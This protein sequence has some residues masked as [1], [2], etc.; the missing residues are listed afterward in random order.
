MAL[1]DCLSCGK[2]Y[3]SLQAECPHCGA[4][5]DERGTKRRPKPAGVGPNIHLLIAM[6]AAIG[7]A[8]WYYSAIA[9]GGDP[10][11][12]RWMIAA[13]LVWYVVARIWAALRSRRR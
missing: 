12:A 1:M 9:T 4:G 7:G 13:G 3:S 11:Y 10:T 6:L 8:G 2:R 5:R